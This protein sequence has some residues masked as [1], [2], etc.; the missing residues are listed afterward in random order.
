MKRTH[1][2]RKKTD[3]NEMLRLAEARHGTGDLSS[4][5]A[6]YHGVLEM[7]PANATALHAAGVI[8]HQINQHDT[9][10]DLVRLAVSI[11]PQ[12]NYLNTL[13]SVWDAL[14]KPDAAMKC[15][16]EAL[17][18]DAAC[19][20]AHCNLGNALR[21]KGRYPEAIECY[22]RALALD[23]SHALACYNLGGVE[24]DLRHF[25]AALE[26]LDH[27]LAINPGFYQVY[28]S[29]GNIAKER[30]DYAGAMELYRRAL[31]LNPEYYECFQGMGDTLAARGLT[32]EAATQYRRVLE[33]FPA[34]FEA[35]NNL[36]NALKDQ[37]RMDEAVRHYEQ[38]INAR[39]GA[40]LPYSNFLYAMN[41]FPD[42]TQDSIAQAHRDFVAPF[43]ASV[44]AARK[45]HE[46]SPDP[47]RRLRVGYV[48]AD[49]RSHAVAFFI[50]PILEAHD[51]GAFE[52]VGYYNSHVVDPVSE[53]L[54]GHFNCFRVV[55]GMEDETV[56]E[57]IRR[58]GID[59][60]VD[61]A[62]HCAGNRIMTFARKPAPVQ[63]TYLGYPATSGLAAMDYRITDA[64]ADP[65][66]ESEGF[67]TEQLMR[68]PHSTWCFRPPSHAPEVAPLPAR[69]RGYVTFGSF[70]SVAK[71]ND[72]V[73]TV[74]AGLLRAVPN[75][76]LLIATVPEG[77][78]REKVLAT[79][80][81]HGVDADRVEFRGKLSSEQFHA[82]HH[83]VDVALDPFPVNGGTT[84]CETLWMGVPVVTLVGGTF[85]GRAG[86]SLLNA[87][88]LSDLVATSKTEYVDIAARLALDAPR[89]EILRMGMR[90]R[91]RAS[92]LFDGPA[93]TRYLEN[94]YRGM[95]Q[96]WCESRGSIAA[97]HGR[98][99]DA[100][101]GAIP[102]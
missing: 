21:K 66:G 59:V 45:E 20:N 60:L 48:S 53:R 78:A 42:A 36:A 26:H 55:A 54:Q 102:G 3:V 22:R 40:L 92:P 61:L 68:M 1:T 31:E 8:A 37:G 84:T 6:L 7:D 51:R 28:C 99:L 96:R 91:L 33:L 58:D 87:V 44:A 70:N 34:C 47:Q 63:V 19:V 80:G 57:L 39:P 5:G 89:L 77:S 15:Y 98:Q 49:L 64:F 4:A 14:G 41:Y 81:P 56:A 13:G 71:V 62:G 101:R 12:A 67:Y 95:W 52:V 43:E 30:G 86:T 35:H 2:A 72:D 10:V 76:R 82:A 65:P 32:E 29:L 88:G 24:S 11:D 69:A 94:E 85:V 50:E 16:G 23:P 46:N 73:L 97:V 17:A 75:S 38:A 74:W 25:D 79:L 83:E 90:D 93:F 18:R 9:A 100:N 27:A